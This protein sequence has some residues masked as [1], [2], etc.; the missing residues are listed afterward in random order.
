MS[1]LAIVA[2]LRQE[3]K[4]IEEMI[5][6]LE[7]QKKEIDEKYSSIIKEENKIYDEIRRCRDMYQYDKLQMRLNVITN[8][9]KTIEQKK[10]EIEK[11]IMG[12]GEEL[13]KVKRRIEYLTPRRGVVSEGGR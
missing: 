11:K 8:Q 2:K 9:R 10:Q 3:Q 6:E 7:K 12:Y 5:S 4:R 1:S 13:E